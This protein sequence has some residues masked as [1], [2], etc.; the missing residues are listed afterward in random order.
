MGYSR[1]VIT[2]RWLK[3]ESPEWDSAWKQLRSMHYS[4]PKV[5]YLEV[6]EKWMYLGT[7][8]RG[9]HGPTR[10]QHHFRHYYHPQTGK[11]ENVFIHSED[12]DPANYVF[13]VP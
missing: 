2:L 6:G 9:P 10:W 7:D 8:Q 12:D 3:E 13:Y 5:T 4:D 11:Q 1:S